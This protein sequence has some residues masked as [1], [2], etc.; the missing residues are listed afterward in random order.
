[1]C[2]LAFVTQL[3]QR[4]PLVLVS[5]R[6]EV[7][8]RMTRPLG[9]SASTGLLWAA[10]GV[11]GGSWLGLNVHD[12]RFATLTNCNR[13]PT[14]PLRLGDDAAIPASWR[15]AMPLDEVVRRMR[16][17]STAAEDGGT[18]VSLEFI[19]HISRGHIVRDFLREGKTPG[20][21]LPPQSSPSHSFSSAEMELMRLRPS[22]APPYFEGYNL[23]TAES[24]FDSRQLRLLYTTN[25]Y[26]AEHKSPAQHG[27][28]HCLANSYLDNWKEPKSALLR[29]RFEEA[30]SK[31]I[32]IDAAPYDAE[33]VADS[34]VSHCLCL[35]PEFDLQKEIMA[36]SRSP[37]V[38]REYED[39]LQASLPY[40]GYK[41]EEE[42]KK[43]YGEGLCPPVHFPTKFYRDIANYHERNI[44]CS[45]SMYGT[46]TQ[47]AVVVEKLRD[48]DG[49]IVHFSQRECDVAG[50]HKPWRHFAVPSPS[51]C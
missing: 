35:Q 31:F 2:I 36:G 28:V 44:F 40:N 37:E 4:F 8:S 39:V 47:T 25:R 14:A 1:M 50:A 13:S 46:R 3:S 45:H 19:P 30:V 10:D 9:V 18:N 51:M 41:G 43:L 6:D 42:L 26:A 12:G 29:E 15:G 16:V 38:L 49:T 20:D 24:L 34:L 17:R 32:P 5:N 22:L 27:V 33:Y 11:A 7:R 21:F 23:L 48:G